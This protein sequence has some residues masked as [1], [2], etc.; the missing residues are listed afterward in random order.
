MPVIS[1]IRRFYRGQFT[2]NDLWLLL[3]P[4]AIF[5]FLDLSLIRPYDFWWH[6]RTGQI[7]VETKSIPT[8]DLFSFTRAGMPW[9][10]QAWLM[11]ALFYW[12]Y[13]LGNLP[14]VIFF[15]ALL[16]SSGYLLLE[17]AC[18]RSNGGQAQAAA[19]AV[20]A[21]AAIGRSDWNIRPQSVSFL[22][23]GAL[24]LILEIHRQRGGRIVWSLPFLFV[25]W[26]NLHGGFVFGIGL[27]GIYIMVHLIQSWRTTHLLLAETRRLLLVGAVS[28]LALA[29]NPRGPM[30][31]LHYILGFF[32]SRASQ[33]LNVEFMPPNIRELDGALFYSAVILLLFIAY[34]RRVRL[35][36]FAVTALLIFGAYSLYSRRVAPWF[37]LVG[38]PAFALIFPP[39]SRGKE[40]DAVP[41][42][43]KLLL[44]YVMVALLVLM[45]FITLPWWRSSLPLPPWRQA[46]VTLFE[47][48]IEATQILCRQGDKT[49]LFN[50][51]AYGSYMIWAC[52]RIPV[53]MDT[54]FELYPD[55][56]WR[57]YLL[58]SN[59]QFGWEEALQ[60]YGINTIFVRKDREKMLVA[61]AMASD[62]WQVIYEDEHTTILQRLIQ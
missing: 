60:K 22:L 25:L 56:M 47:T 24:V 44:N 7:I 12:L 43:G 3:P 27:L 11:Q 41:G 14:L 18:L 29:A 33:T 37:G 55:A 28:L 16:I 34:V 48:P 19:L 38:A 53:F 50:D 35:S 49:R 26:V 30:G 1:A 23:L 31:I 57:D 20:I 15:H 6:L 21:A 42:R 4:L 54:R 59:A 46:Y 13:Q 8:T 61:A 45:V 39:Q 10:N 5:I 51:L 40:P 36:S 62:V 17:L 58:I 9:T 2:L 52:P 32:Q